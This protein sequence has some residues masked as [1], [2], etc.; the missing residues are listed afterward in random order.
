M[1]NL[2]AIWHPDYFLIN[3]CHNNK[4]E[5]RPEHIFTLRKLFKIVSESNLYP[6]EIIMNEDV[7][8]YCTFLTSTFTGRHFCRVT[9]S[10][11]LA[12]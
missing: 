4:T 7:S 12:A 6:L 11:F 1:Q 9:S 3:L 5:L 8:I 10:S 2:H